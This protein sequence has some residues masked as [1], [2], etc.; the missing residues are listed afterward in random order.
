MKEDLRKKSDRRA[1]LI[2]ATGFLCMFTIYAISLNC[3]GLFLKPM[4]E[5]FDAS[6]AT[7]SGITSISMIVGIPMTLIYGVIFDKKAVKIP[8]AIGCFIT[9]AGYMVLAYAPSIAI[10]YVGAILIG[11]GASGAMQLPISVVLNNWFVEKKGLAMGIAF[12]GSGVGGVVFSQLINYFI[13]AHSWRTAYLVLGLL[14]I[15][16]TVIPVSLFVTKTPEAVGLLPYG[17]K[18]KHSADETVSEVRA[19]SS[20][21]L[22]ATIRTSEFWLY[23]LGAAA[24]SFTMSAIKGHIPAYMTDIGY[25]E[26]VAANIL[27]I[28]VLT[29]IPGK[30]ILGIVFDKLGSKAGTLT[31]IGLMI[32]GIL[33]LIFTPVAFLFAIFFGICYGVGSAY[34]TV[35]PAM[36]IGDVFRSSSSNYGTIFSISSTGATLAGAIGPAIF[37]AIFDTTGSYTGAWILGIAGLFIGMVLVVMAVHITHKK[38]TKQQ[39]LEV[40]YEN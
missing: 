22:M 15:L 27:S 34:A 13:V 33:L 1:W 40:Q 14:T 16:I 35:G 7:I 2:V 21:S 29:V 37:G 23:F 25:T 38:Y 39:T 30:P 3:L 9:G 6:R 8:M 26:Q 17:K 18:K 11:I 24:I 5:T 32:L 10:C 36:V 20:S 31:S 19:Q 28:T 12:S 4:A